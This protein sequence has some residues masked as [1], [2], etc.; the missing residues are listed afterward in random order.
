[1]RTSCDL[2]KACHALYLV[3]VLGLTQTRTAVVLELNVGTVC[4]IVHKRRFP[5]AFPIPFPI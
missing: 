4:H 2:L 3:H 1:M 5:N